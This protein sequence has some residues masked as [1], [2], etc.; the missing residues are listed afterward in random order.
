ML[1]DH[2]S[3]VVVYASACENKVYCIVLYCIDNS[4]FDENGK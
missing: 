3:H 2:Q 1:Y 4:K